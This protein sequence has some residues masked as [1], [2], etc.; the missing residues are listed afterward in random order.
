MSTV[1]S[2]FREKFVHVFASFA[3]KRDAKKNENQNMPYFRLFWSDFN[4]S[5]AKMQCFRLE[6]LIPDV[7]GIFKWL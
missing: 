2:I 1:N 5:Y 4:V 6:G 3:K 7:I